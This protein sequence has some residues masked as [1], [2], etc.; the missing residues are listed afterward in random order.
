M[1]E[2][3]MN[4]TGVRMNAMPRRSI[5]AVLAL[6]LAAF[7]ASTANATAP[8]VMTYQGRVKEAGVP[9]TGARNITV[10]ICPDG[11]TALVNCLDTGAQS[12]SV[13]NGLFRTTFTAPGISWENGTRYLHLRVGAVDFSPRELIAA[14]PYSVYASSAA[15]LIPNTGAPHV[16]IASSVVIGTAL[17]GNSLEVVGELKIS[18][19]NHIRVPAGATNPVVISG[20]GTGATVVGSDTVGRITLGTGAP[21]NCKIGFGVTWTGNLPV[22]YFNNETTNTAV[23]MTSVSLFDV[24][25][26]AVTGFTPLDVISYICMNY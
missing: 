8:S 20:C 15:T 4:R 7:A 12:V 16:A 22:C 6:I 25:A 5:P 11:V 1:I 23:R 14:I 2:Y 17:A 24:T 21:A 19:N 9:V 3:F 18:G 13:T 10:F 26:T